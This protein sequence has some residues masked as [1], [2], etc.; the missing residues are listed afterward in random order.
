MYITDENFNTEVLQS[1]EPV[2]VDFHASWCGPCRMLTPLIAEITTEFS[3]RAKIVKM[4]IDESPETP[5]TYGVRAIPCLILFKDGKE[6]DRKVGMLSKS[7]LQGWINEAIEGKKY[8]VFENP[9]V[10]DGILKKDD[11][12]ILFI[13][14]EAEVKQEGVFN[15]LLEATEAYRSHSP[16]ISKE[17]REKPAVYEVR[18][19][20]EMKLVRID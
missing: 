2:V 18:E 19:V 13:R 12:Y 3:G 20:K 15:T 17:S 16:R 9:G 6:I 10:E 4:N 7:Q 8:P 14:G 11:L 5:S 1:K